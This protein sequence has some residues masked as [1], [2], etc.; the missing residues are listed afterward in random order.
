MVRKDFLEE[1]LNKK[2]LHILFSVTGERSAWTNEDTTGSSTRR[3][4]YAFGIGFELDH[5]SSWYD[6]R[7]NRIKD[8]K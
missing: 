5:L 8:I 1:V 4:F 7:D 3:D 6:D 2:K